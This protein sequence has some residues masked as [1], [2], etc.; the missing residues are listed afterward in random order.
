MDKLTIAKLG[1]LTPEQKTETFDRLASEIFPT[2]T[3][4]SKD[5]SNSLGI[6]R[7][8]YFG[9]RRDNRVPDLAILLMQEWAEKE[10]HSDVALI[11]AIT[12]DMRQ[13]SALFGQVTKNLAELGDR[14]ADAPTKSASGVAQPD[15]A[16]RK[17]SEA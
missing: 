12:D 6:T 11:Q 16:S 17:S 7:G 13:I 15:P 3:N 2:T 1:D 14:L 5:L 4:M 10:T 8:S 9:W